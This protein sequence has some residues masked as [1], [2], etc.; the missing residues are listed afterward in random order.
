MLG[1]PRQ[2]KDDDVHCEYPVDADDEYVTERGFQPLL[3][4]ESTRLSSALALFRATRILSKVLEEVYPALPSYD[5]SLQKLSA[6]SEELDQWLASLPTH[7]RLTFAQD[8]PS[9][10]TISS[11]SPLLS[12]TYHYIRALIHRPAVCASLG[13]RSS[14]SMI[15]MTASSK[16]IVQ[17]IQLLAERGLTFAFCLHKE[18]LL[19]LSGL[20]LL[21]QSLDLDQD[22]KLLRDN[23]KTLA[24]IMSALDSDKASC[25]AEFRRV[26]CSFLPLAAS[27]NR[28]KAVPVSRHNS[29]G[30]MPAPSLSSI[31]P[32]LK[33]H[34]KAMTAKFVPPSMRPHNKPSAIDHRRATESD[35]SLYRHQLMAQSQ[36]TFASH[37]PSH[38]SRSEPALSPT[39]M[40]L[41]KP[42]SGPSPHPHSS[43]RSSAML[44]R[45]HSMNL[46]YLSFGNTPSGTPPLRSQPPPI[47]PV[48][49]EPSDWERLLGS[50]DGGQTNIFDNIYGGPRVD[51]AHDHPNTTTNTNKTNANKQQHPFSSDSA[52][53]RTTSAPNQHVSDIAEDTIGSDFSANWDTPDIWGLSTADFGPVAAD[54]PPPALSE[55]VISFSTDEGGC[56]HGS[57]SGSSGHMDEALAFGTDWNIGE[58]GYRDGIG[59]TATTDGSSVSSA[60]EFRGICMPSDFGTGD[61]G[62]LG[63]A[64]E[65]IFA[66]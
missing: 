29:D 32:A 42:S 61:D 45:N 39:S 38:V 63:N 12:L 13:S 57:V 25:A 22:S 18:E 60:N 41:Q 11:R 56:R 15:A 47:V 7:L 6:L 66:A 51:F 8:K 34:F 53:H 59:V 46:D 48:K 37:S 44:S 20:G 43:K 52:L 55:S 36:P 3:P 54:A 33:Q 16:H 10:G 27:P 14:S 24:S 1:L 40:Y 9:T 2:I 26:A 58:H 5:L 21:Y 65:S 49:T 4:G 62:L 28:E 35:I 23:Q 31:P 64:W 17:I 19:V 30:A 50:I